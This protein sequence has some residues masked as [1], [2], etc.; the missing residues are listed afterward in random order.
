MDTGL[1]LTESIEF[2]RETLVRKWSRWL[3]FLLL[4]LPWIA[5]S[6]LIDTRKIIDGTTI[7]WELVPWAVI[8]PVVAAGIVLSF[9]VSGYTVRLLKAGDA[10]PEFD[11]WA[12]LA[13]DGIRMEIII[14]IWALPFILFVWF[15]LPFVNGTGFSLAS[16]L[17]LP[18]LMFV[19]LLFLAIVAFFGLIGL[20][21][22]ARTGRIRE[23]FAFRK[24]RSDID[25]IGW[26]EYFVGF[27]I[28]AL[29][30]LVFT[31]VTG[32]LSLIPFAGILIPFVLG[33]LLT[34]FQFRFVACVYGAGETGPAPGP[35]SA[36]VTDTAETPSWERISSSTAVYFS[37]SLRSVLSRCTRL[38]T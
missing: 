3:V 1:I 11:N 19:G 23:A 13:L 29:V 25:R 26:G 32:T 22:F 4:T 8:V 17:L 36:A 24:I 14:A 27:I 31:V 37:F 33:P 5:V 35:G 21:R 10:P 12:A 18:L 30:R 15:T 28:V 16:L 6:L 38:S 7:H 2:T 20:V 9:F 34:V